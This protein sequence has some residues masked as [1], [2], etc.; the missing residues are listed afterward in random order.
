VPWGDAPVCRICTHDPFIEDWVRECNKL[1][2]GISAP[3]AKDGVSVGS[4]PACLR[5]DAQM[6][7]AVAVSV[8]GMGS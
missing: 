4:A 1:V 6:A 3:R 2:E 5:F 7:L 8:L